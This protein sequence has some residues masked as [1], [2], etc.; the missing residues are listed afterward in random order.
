MSETNQP[1]PLPDA[2]TPSVD[3][4]PM[5]HKLNNELST[6]IPVIYGALMSYAIYLVGEAAIKT[7]SHTEKLSWG[8]IN[9]KNV[10]YNL[11][12]LYLPIGMVFT[13]MLEDFGEISKLK[14]DFPYIGL[15]RLSHEVLICT[16]FSITL[17]FLSIQNM[18]GLVT[19]GMAVIWGGIW[20]VLLQKEYSAHPSNLKSACKT[21]ATI[22]IT[23]GFL[24]ILPPALCIMATNDARLRYSVFFWVAAIYIIWKMCYAKTMTKQHPEFV[25]RYSVD[26]SLPK[27]LL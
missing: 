6:V 16:L 17:A 19:F 4:E 5:G 13:L 10:A 20:F 26:I 9:C 1:P 23:G 22:Q 7:F 27:I 8:F 11:G 3:L 12:L 21:A 25:A 18:L 2:F 15:W 24:F 14:V